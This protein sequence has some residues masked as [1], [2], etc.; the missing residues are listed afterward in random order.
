MANNENWDWKEWG[1]TLVIVWGAA[2]ILGFSNGLSHPPP[3]TQP[4]SVVQVS[5]PQAREDVRSRFFKLAD[6]LE[7]VSQRL[8]KA[9]PDIAAVAEMRSIAKRLDKLPDIHTCDET[10]KKRIGTLVKDLEIME[11]KPKKTDDPRREDI[12]RTENVVSE[13]IAVR[14]SICE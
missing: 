5:S 14:K 1:L 13:V 12:E 9:S 11:V 10:L 7:I 2:A 4:V 6:S 3:T 8:N